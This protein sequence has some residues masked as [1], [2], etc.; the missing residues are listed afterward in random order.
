MT[1]VNFWFIHGKTPEL[2]RPMQACRLEAL[3]PP[4]GSSLVCHRISATFSN[5][6]SLKKEFKRAVLDNSIVFEILLTVAEDPQLRTVCL[7]PTKPDQTDV[8]CLK[9]DREFQAAGE[10]FYISDELSLRESTRGLDAVLIH[11]IREILRHFLADPGS[12]EIALTY[13]DGT[14]FTTRLWVKHVYPS[15]EGQI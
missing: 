7:F 12:R 6:S 10:K 5:L 9:K 3:K 2:Y 15:S 4:L 11:T 8:L 13:R 1:T 14:R